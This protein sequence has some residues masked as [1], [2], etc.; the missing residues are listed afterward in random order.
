MHDCKVMPQVGIP[1]AIAKV[2]DAPVRNFSQNYRADCLV[3]IRSECAICMVELRV[4]P[5]LAFALLIV[6]AIYDAAMRQAHDLGCTGKS[7]S[8]MVA[9]LR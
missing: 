2:L 6:S 4:A 7:K 1:I 3:S 9:G 5:A 8:L